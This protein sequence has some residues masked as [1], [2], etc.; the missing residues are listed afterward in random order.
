M[1]GI[2][3][4]SMLPMGTSRLDI[5]NKE[6]LEF[7]YRCICDMDND[8]FQKAVILKLRTKKQGQ[9]QW[10]PTPAE[11]LELG[12]F[13]EDTENRQASTADE[14]WEAFSTAFGHIGYRAMRETWDNGEQVFTDATTDKVAQTMAKDFANSDVSESGNWRS[15][16]IKSYDNMKEHGLKTAEMQ[17]I[18]GL[19]TLSATKVEGLSVNTLSGGR[20]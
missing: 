5:N 17:K 20:K 1:Q 15:R 11:L 19:L 12:G 7:Y 9:P 14:Q 10:F 2:R 18:N 13:V 6:D 16:F 8:Q 3:A 4:L